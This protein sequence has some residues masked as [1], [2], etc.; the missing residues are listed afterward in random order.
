ML[1]KSF[2]V[3]GWFSCSLIA[4]SS[5]S[6]A[7]GD[8]PFVRGDA[9]ETGS[10][11][12]TDAVSIVHHVFNREFLFSFPVRCEDA[13]D[14]NDDG[15]VNVTDALYLLNALFVGG[16]PPAAPF[17]E[18]GLDPTGDEIA[19]ASSQHCRPAIYGLPLA[20]DSLF[21]VVDKSGTMMDTGEFLIA[22]REVLGTILRLPQ[23]TEFGIVFFDTSVVRFPPDGSP[24]L[25]SP[26]TATQAAGFVQS[27]AGG[28]GSCVREGLVAAIQM[29]K[30]SQGPRKVLV[31][32][33][34]G[35]GTC[36]G[37]DEVTYLNQTLSAVAALNQGEVTIHA[38][39]VLDVHPINE[40]FLQDLAEAN[41]G[42]YRRVEP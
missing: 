23:G 28:G 11:S 8:V 21:V 6:S 35:G 17:P 15:A 4:S 22:K 5:A 24:A 3:F 25:A 26:E 16:P 27:I 13:A 40:K 20:F 38:V 36:K 12:V 7:E 2:V 41:G 42:T 1:S 32:V 10:I 39:G 33:G 37:A 30:R 19:C 29:A 31:Y 14:A 34:D 9:D 18:C